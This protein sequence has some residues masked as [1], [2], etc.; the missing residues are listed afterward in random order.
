M[1]I[2]IFPGLGYRIINQR[3]VKLQPWNYLL[4]IAKKLADQGYDI[5]IMPI[6]VQIDTHLRRFFLLN[7]INVV[8]YSKSVVK[9]SNLIVSPIAIGFLTKITRFFNP[10]TKI[11]GVLTTPL[12]PLSVLIRNYPRI[13]LSRTD[14]SLDS[15]MYE[16][17]LFRLR[18]KMICDFVRKIIVPSTD[19]AGLLLD[20]LPCDIEI[21]KISPQID[22][23]YIEYISKQYSRQETENLQGS[24]KF[25]ITYFGP[26]TEERGVISLIKA[27][28][29]IIRTN[30]E[31]RLM[32]L[33]R[34]IGSKNLL[35]LRDM[36]EKVDRNKIYLHI[37]FMGKES[38]MKKLLLSDIIVLPYRILSSVIPLAFIEA[39]ML[40][41]PLVIS[42]SIPGINEHIKH[43]LYN[44]LN[45]SY[46]VGQ[47]THTLVSIIEDKRFYKMLI[48]KQYSYI[49]HFSQ[50]IRRASWE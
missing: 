16:N 25:T 12:I 41:K 44:I 38:L 49:L 34:S 40:N 17:I 3:T 43:Y 32:L 30:R 42:T 4:Q 18:A 22:I 47:L 7:R 23:Q 19:F 14:V 33:I 39:L 5:A 1:F 29:Q 6:N 27:F 46:T 15:I 21:I 45:P 48:H 13:K 37:G 20:I 8:P 28:K 26:F 24:R 35:V 2:I 10:N 50:K 31:I 9:A 36:I 11:I